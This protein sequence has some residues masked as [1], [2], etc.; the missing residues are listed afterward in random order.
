[1]KLFL[2]TSNVP[3]AR[4]GKPGITAVNVI[5]YEVVQALRAQGHQLTL[6]IISDVHR[7]ASTLSELEAEALG[8]LAGAGITVLPPIFRDVYLQ[9]PRSGFV[10]KL[11]RAT[12]TIA[13]LVSPDTGLSLF[14]PA[15]RAGHELRARVEA[16]G[17][18]AALAL[19]SHE[20]VAATHGL[21]R[22]PRIS[23]HGDVDFVPSLARF[24]NQTLFGADD[25]QHAMASVPR[26]ITRLLQRAR[27]RAFER[28]HVRLMNEVNVLAN[29]T[30]CNA[31]FYRAHGHPFSVYVGNTWSEPSNA[32]PNLESHLTEWINHRPVKIIGHAG[33]LGATASTFG[34]CFLLGEVLP[35]LERLMV[36]IEYEVHVVGGG[37]P[38]PALRGLLNH[39]RVRLRGFVEELD[40]E[41]REAP[42]YLLLNNAGPFQ[43]AFTRHLVAW[44]IGA[45]LVV[46]S[47]S[48]RAI[49][50]V[51]PGENVL[52]GS[53]GEE[54]AQA[55]FNG[56][57]DTELNARI[58]RGG[59]ETYFRYFTP[60]RIASELARLAA[61]TARQNS[62]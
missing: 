12:E 54:V 51:V 29:L 59:Q 19:I 33:R 20:G 7:T 38:V 58:R 5:L 34:L 48:R 57:T 35:H 14:Y 41:L 8:E 15:A 4:H 61:E 1:M 23:Y 2:L 11:R 53:T 26:Q 3:H 24:Q 40:H 43:A 45:C 37:A 17:A 9:A 25:A 22:I 62:R 16:S 56:V 39:P 52:A 28:A 21:R 42:V 36:G 32:A 10:G 31:D 30:A 27:L 47:N 55:I 18:E 13:A 6:Q 44:S 60:R 50:E 46:H 49:P